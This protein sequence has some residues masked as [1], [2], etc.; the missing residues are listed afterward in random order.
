MR[1]S[2][3]FPNCGWNDVC[4]EPS[5]LKPEPAHEKSLAPRG[6]QYRR[7]KCS[8]SRSCINLS[9]QGFSRTH[10]HTQKLI[11]FI[12]P[13]PPPLLIC[14]GLPVGYKVKWK[15][16]AKQAHTFSPTLSP[17]PWMYNL[18]PGSLRA[19]SLGHSGGGAGKRRKACNYISGIWIPLQ[20]PLWFFVDWAVIFSLISA[21]RKR[22]QCKQT[23]KNTCQE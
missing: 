21:K 16:A 20:V 15:H 2:S 23:L 11:E 10:A 18:T 9:V 5:V 1:A 22:A 8:W 17:K 7:T 13:P 6:G 14:L 3:F 4:W 19:S 12:A